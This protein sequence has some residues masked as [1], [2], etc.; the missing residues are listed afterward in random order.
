MTGLTEYCMG[1][2][3]QSFAGRLVTTLTDVFKNR[4]KK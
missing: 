2:S 1:F 4:K 3:K